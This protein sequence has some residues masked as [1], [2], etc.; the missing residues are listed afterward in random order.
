M[1]DAKDP[2]QL[3]RQNSS[4]EIC[5]SKSPQAEDP[6]FCVYKSRAVKRQRSQLSRPV[7]S[8][9]DHIFHSPKSHCTVESLCQS[10]VRPWEDLPVAKTANSCRWSDDLYDFDAKASS[11]Y[12]GMHTNMCS[13]HLP[14]STVARNV[15]AVI[16]HAWRLL[17]LVHMIDKPSFKTSEHDSIKGVRGHSLG[18][19]HSTPFLGYAILTAVDVLSAA[20]SVETYEETMTVMHQ[21][22]AILDELSNVWVSAKG[23]S[24]LVRRRIDVLVESVDS[25][26]S[27]DKSAWKC[28]C[29][30]DASLGLGYDVFYDSVDMKR[31]KLFEYLGINVREDEILLVN[32]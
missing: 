18:F 27:K 8:K 25:K 22:L 19:G 32:G 5:H 2:L 31:T 17:Q 30:L 11:H 7:L 28:K 29:P 13:A 12:L 4:P 21:S 20:G 16:D 10:H 1:E 24:R 14:A 6:L 9:A 3:K 15:R 23:Q 26:E